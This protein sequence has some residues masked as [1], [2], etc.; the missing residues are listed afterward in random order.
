MK[1]SRKQCPQPIRLWELSLEKRKDTFWSRF[2]T[3]GSNAAAHLQTVQEL[4]RVLRNTG[5]GKKHIILQYNA[6]PTLFLC[7][8]RGFRRIARLLSPPSPNPKGPHHLF[9]HPPTHLFWP[10]TYQ[11]RGRN[12]GTKEAVQEAVG[13]CL[14]TDETVLPEGFSNFYRWHKC[15]DLDGVSV[16]K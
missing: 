7:A 14:R 2:A 15:N 9:T 5:R 16:H 1:R 4:P 13:R 10:L 3:R 12:N 11:M 6:R 8:W